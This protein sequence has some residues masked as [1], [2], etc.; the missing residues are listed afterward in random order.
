VYPVKADS[1]MTQ[2]PQELTE[3]PQLPVPGVVMGLLHDV[4]AKLHLTGA[5]F[6]RAE[7]TAPW[8]IETP[9]T[10]ELASI[11]AP[12]ARRLILF[13]V[14][15]E[16]RFWLR[17]S[18]GEQV[19]AEEGEVVV[20][21]YSHQHVM[22]SDE[23]ADPVP[24]AALFP[25][26]PWEQLPMIRHGGGGARTK[27]VCG[28][29]Y[30]DDP[31]F[32][33]VMAALPAVFRVKPPPGPAANWVVASIQYALDV[34][35]GHPAAPR[36]VAVRLPELLFGEVLRLYVES[37]A[38]PRSGW[39]AA[40]RDPIVGPALIELHSEP[41]RRWTVEELARRVACSRSLLNERFGRLLGRAPM[42]YLGE[43][44]LQIAADLL[45]STTLGVAAV[46]YRVGYESEEAFSRSFKRALGSPP[47]QWRYSE[48]R[49]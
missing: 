30:C 12:Q 3:A 28:Y 33:P 44:R 27:I 25:P 23:S 42:Q 17:V 18:T 26:P 47:S 45:R 14:I 7:N 11:L 1:T 48:A 13:H 22:G 41:A 8:A 39:L 36:G 35:Q 40:L 38:P 20:L 19:Q 4:L 49:V 34:S 31:I 10:A 9:A 6:V 15:A 16:G 37:A 43:W 29:L 21:P 46:A 32:E 5:F 24:I 2:T